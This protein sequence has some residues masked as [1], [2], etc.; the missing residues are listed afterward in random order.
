[1]RVESGK[2]TRDG[3]EKGENGRDVRKKQEN[4]G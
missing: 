4:E 1:L 2:K 3:R